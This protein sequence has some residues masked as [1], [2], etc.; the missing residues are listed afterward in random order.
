M[1]SYVDS[2]KLVAARAAGASTAEIHERA[3]AGKFTP[4]LPVDP[5][6]LM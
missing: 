1:G 2:E 6:V 5:R 4:A 3:Y